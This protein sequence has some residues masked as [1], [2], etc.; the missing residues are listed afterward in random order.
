[1]ATNLNTEIP[2]FCF[3]FNGALRTPRNLIAFDLPFQ[4]KDLTNLR[5]E[6]IPKGKSA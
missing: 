4:N 6:G 5:A 2:E 3:E 1:M